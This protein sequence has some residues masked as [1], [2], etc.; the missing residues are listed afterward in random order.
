MHLHL[1]IPGLLWPSEQARGFADALPLPALTLLLGRGQTRRQH[2]ES[3]EQAW[4]RIFKLAPETA[5]DASL[6]RLGEDDGL[7]ETDTVMCA[8][9][10]HLH[11]ARE[12]LLLADASELDI[13]DDEAQTLVAS[14][15]DVF[16]DIG[17]F[18][19]P[20]PARWYLYPATL[21]TARFSP[22]GD[23]TSRPVAHFM[24]S[25]E[26][27]AMWQRTMNEIQIHFHNHPLNAEREARGRRAINSV[28]LWGAGSLP[29]SLNAPAPALVMHSPLA[30]GL[31]RAA[32][33]EPGSAQQLAALAPGNTLVE[34][35]TLLG[36]SRYLDL[37][38]WQA[39]LI[40]LEADWFAPALAALRGRRLSRL[41]LSVP[42]E[43]GSLSVDVTPS[44]LLQFWRRLESLEAFTI[45]NR[46]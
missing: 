16:G 26:D 4:R 13:R 1:V 3:P 31:A 36:A 12:H 5:A 14:L 11:F 40:Q 25:G 17:R 9:P 37:E 6:R 2:A 42:D 45:V 8:D 35:D 39:A 22:L 28:W 27:A 19:A 34:L 24:P 21:P 30:R 18:E 7:R 38:P 46:L 44:R 20:A 23:V 10:V 15:N 32:G 33:V 41:T 29:P 43:R